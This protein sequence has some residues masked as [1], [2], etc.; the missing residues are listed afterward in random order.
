MSRVSTQSADCLVLGA[1]IVGICTALH[2]QRRGRQVLLIDRQ[3]PMAETS[4]GNAGLIQV[5]AVMP[6]ACPQN[7]ALMRRV[8]AGQETAARVHWSS[9]PTI[10][11]WLWRYYRAGRSDAVH[12]TARALAPLVQRALA[13]HH[14]LMQASGTGHL[15]RS[16]G[17]LRLFREPHALDAAVEID[18]RTRDEFGIRFDVLDSAELQSLEPGLHVASTSMLAIHY[19]E[20]ERVIDAGELGL[21]YFAHYQ[22][23]GGGFVRGDARTLE[24]R[25]DH[26]QLTSDEGILRARS[27]VIALGP[28]S[29][30][31]LA[32]LGRPVPLGIKRGYHRHFEQGDGLG[33]S[34]LVLDDAHGV[35][36]APNKRGVRVT[37][38][39]EFARRDAPPSSAQL[40]RAESIARSLCKL[41][42]P[43]ESAG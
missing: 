30:E 43:V 17:Y 5:E 19:P 20:P 8:L 24:R 11:P 7:T 1:G 6:Y 34:H 37:I 42:K 21:G 33:L 23:E 3:A 25:A 28:W 26:W 4:Y 40:G 38:G 31:L 2:L 18:T 15:C 36:V 32:R 41:G 14:D 10:A 13:E 9:L 27:I 12:V 35:V 39:V 22:G 29:G 16:G